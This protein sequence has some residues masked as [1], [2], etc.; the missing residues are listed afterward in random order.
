MNASDSR[1][2]SQ[3]RVAVHRSC[4]RDLIVVVLLTRDTVS[5]HALPQPIRS[6][7]SLFPR[8]QSVHASLAT[9]REPVRATADW[10]DTGDV[11]R[12]TRK[13]GC[14]VATDRHC[15]PD[16]S[17]ALRSVCNSFQW[18]QE[19]RA[20]AKM[21]AAMRVGHGETCRRKLTTV[22]RGVVSVYS[23]ATSSIA[24]VSSRMDSRSCSPMWP[25]RNVSSPSCEP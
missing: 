23:P 22:D 14:L 2:Q 19:I 20:G 18:P 7:R 21:E 5:H 17:A 6:L 10:S 24:S 12:G 8:V 16:R 11:E 25:I 1:R 13:R 4:V 9:R 3:P 15:T